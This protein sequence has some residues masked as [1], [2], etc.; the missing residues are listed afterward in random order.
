[1]KTRRTCIHFLL[2]LLTILTLCGCTRSAPP[3]ESYQAAGQESGG[4]NPNASAQTDP[5]LPSGEDAAGQTDG[6]DAPARD[7]R[8]VQAEFDAFTNRLFCEALSEDP[9][10]LHFTLRRPDAFGITVSKMHFPDISAKRL[11]ED[12]E[13]NEEIQEELASFDPSLLT[14]EQLFTY[15]LLQDQLDTEALSRGLEIYYQPLSPVI[16]VQAQLPVLLAEYAF[17]EKADVDQYLDLLSQIDTYYAKL[18]DYEKERADAGLAPCDTAIDR[19]LQSCKDYLIRPENSFMTE[20]FQS[21]LDEVPGLSDAEKAEYKKKHLSILKE[22]FI[23][24]YT[25]LSAAL[26]ELKGR[27]SNELG[28]CHYEK[29]KA[30]YEY[31]VASLTGTDSTVPELRDRIEKKLGSDMAEIS[32][33]MQNHPDLHNQISKADISLSDPVEILNH[34]REQIQND[35]P[36]LEDS[37]FEVK[38]VPKALESSLSPAFFLIP[39][40]DSEDTNIIYINDKLSQQQNLYTTLAHE[41]YPGHLYQSVYFNRKNPCPLHRLLSCDGYSEGWGLYSELYSYSFDNG[42]SEPMKEMM[43]HSEASIYALYAL[44]DIH[45]NYDG[46][47]LDKTADF[48]ET[49]YGITDREVAEEI[50][51][52]LIDNPVN[53]LKYYTGY[54]E[55]CTLKS[56]AADT[57]GAKY[58]VKAFHKFILDMEGAPFRVIKPYFQTWLLTYDVKQ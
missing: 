21:R 28:L 7:P 17:Y 11:R 16:G 5:T 23:P 15:R 30:Y 29:G 33:L 1:M 13:E 8:T 47:D 27:G 42:L 54:L 9:M 44:L 48:L 45:V 36:P 51:R 40:L 22:H 20:T 56:S 18:A 31:L 25:N 24:A 4:Q 52:A 19:I 14:S 34:L 10:S 12:A 58:N 26:E 38:H 35:F 49:Y 53:Y 3:V 37:S 39:P 6:S 43:M 57:L 2:I 41:G 50:F 55:I 46:W 32:L